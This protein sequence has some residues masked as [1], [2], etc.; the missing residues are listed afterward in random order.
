MIKFKVFRKRQ[1]RASLNYESGF[2]LKNGA[3]ISSCGGKKCTTSPLI[4]ATRSYF[5]TLA[6]TRT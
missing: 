6:R 4:P 2:S 5:K 3:I 1:G